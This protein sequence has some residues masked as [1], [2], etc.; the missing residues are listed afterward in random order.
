MP[1]HD[2]HLSDVLDQVADGWILPPDF[3]RDWLWDNDRIISILATV[4]MDYPMGVIMT[5]DRVPTI[6]LA[7]NTSALIR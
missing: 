7:R 2:P 3:Q 4:T 6:K 1:L 5:L